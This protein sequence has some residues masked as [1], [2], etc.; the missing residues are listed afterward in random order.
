MVG[1]PA[2]CLGDCRE[3]RAPQPPALPHHASTP[4][5]VAIATLVE[6]RSVGAHGCQ[7]AAE[8]CYQS[9]LSESMGKPPGPD[10]G[11]AFGARL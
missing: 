10:K 1:G 9:R 6:K 7:G 11:E 8:N 4:R 2:A 3:F 5:R